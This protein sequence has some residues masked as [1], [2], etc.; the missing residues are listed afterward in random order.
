MYGTTKV[1]I[2]THHQVGDADADALARAAA[3]AARLLSKA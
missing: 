2:V 1:R 3:A